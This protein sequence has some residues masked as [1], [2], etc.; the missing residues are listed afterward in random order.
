MDL[1][2]SHDGALAAVARIVRRR[3][4]ARD[5]DLEKMPAPEDLLG[6]ARYVLRCQRV[7][8]EVLAQDTCDALRIV[9]ALRAQ[10]DEAE[11]AL[12]RST[13]RLRITWAQTAAVL[14]LHSPQAAQQRLVRLGAAAG[15][16]V[17]S[18][19]HERG[20]RA[21]ARDASAWLGENGA[22]VL[23]LASAVASAAHAE[24][25]AADLAEDLAEELAEDVPSPRA[26]VALLSQ[27]HKACPATGCGFVGLGPLVTAWDD[28]QGPPDP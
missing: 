7:S 24:P 16:R 28:V 20:R 10:A 11:L 1:S 3:E 21:V 17:R 23:D 18:E 6:V 27:M 26:L 9:A 8:R 22:Q 25:G 15:G 2:R 19:L 5:D 13:R 14:G 12:L 4:R